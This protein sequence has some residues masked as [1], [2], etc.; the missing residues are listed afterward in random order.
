MATAYLLTDVVQEELQ[1]VFR[2]GS[3]HSL[4][5]ERKHQLDKLSSQAVK[6]GS[7]ADL[8]SFVVRGMVKRASEHEADVVAERVRARVLRLLT[9]RE[10]RARRVAWA[11][12]RAVYFGEVGAAGRPSVGGGG[13][14]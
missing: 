13:Y 12:W 3:A 7:E 11:Q 1:Q 5:V 2:K 8:S 14:R 9:S 6:D 4:S 10:T